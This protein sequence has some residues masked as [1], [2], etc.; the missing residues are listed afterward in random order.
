MTFKTF[1]KPS[2]SNFVVLI[3]LLCL[4]TYWF[5]PLFT[6]EYGPVGKAHYG[7]G[8]P[9]IVLTGLFLKGK[10]IDTFWPVVLFMHHLFWVL[11]LLIGFL[12]MRKSGH[13]W[14]NALRIGIVVFFLFVWLPFF[15]S[16]LRNNAN[17]GQSELVPQYGLGYIAVCVSLFL[18]VMVLVFERKSHYTK[19]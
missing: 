17:A 12:A 1:N 3:H 10:A 5:F 19:V 9:A 4:L 13:F 11:Y 6:M 8:V 15:E 2:I 18:S 16:L 7:E 14:A